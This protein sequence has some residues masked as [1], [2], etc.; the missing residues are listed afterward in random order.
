MTMMLSIPN[1]RAPNFP[2]NKVRAR[3]NAYQRLVTCYYYGMCLYSNI[4]T[5]DTYS[6]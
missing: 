5:R 6:Q 2:D 4:I 3:F 1:F